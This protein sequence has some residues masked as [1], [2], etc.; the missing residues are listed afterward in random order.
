MRDEGGL[1][2]VALVV[3]RLRAHVEDDVVLLGVHEL[4]CRFGVDLPV[5]GGAA[6]VASAFILSGG[7]AEA[8]GESCEG[9]DARKGGGD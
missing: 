7:C 3:F 2:D 5:G 6:G 9:D 1:G 4:L 8:A